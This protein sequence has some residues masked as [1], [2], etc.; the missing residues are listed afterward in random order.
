MVKVANLVADTIWTPGAG[1]NDTSP[2]LSIFL[3]TFRR[4]ADGLLQKVMQ[5]IADQTFRD[6]E[7]I[8]I[9]DAS[10]DGSAGI[11][12]DWMARDR[13]ISCLTHP[14][15]VGL[16]A[17][18]EFEA[19]LKS[20]GRFIGFAFDDFVYEPG[21]FEALV[22][23]ARAHPDALVHGYAEMVGWSGPNQFL[24]RAGIPAARLWHDNFI[25]NAT[26]LMPRQI[27]EA[28]GFY[29]PHI[30]AA[31]N[32][33]WDLWRRAQRHYPIVPIPVFIG[34]EHGTGRA[35]SLGRTYPVFQEVM[36]EFYGGRSNDVLLP[37]NL[38][39]RDVW[40]VP[41]P[42]SFALA[43]AAISTRKFF[44]NKAWA[45]SETMA[46]TADLQRLVEPK[47]PIIGV[48]GSLEATIS[49]CFDGVR[50]R[51]ASNLRFV[52][53]RS[54][55]A[56]QAQHI[57][58]CDAVIV[59]RGLLDSNAER[60]IGL[61]TSTGIDLH[62]LADD[63]PILIAKEDAELSRYRLDKVR[64]VLKP[65]KG[66]LATSPRLAEYYRANGLHPNVQL[67]G[68]VLDRATLGKMRRIVAEAHPGRL[69]VGFIGGGFREDDLRARVYPALRTLSQRTG[70]ELIARESDGLRRNPP[71]SPLP[72]RQIP[73]AL[74][75]DSFLQ[76]WRSL[77]IDVLVHPK[78]Q[79]LNIDY[80]TDSILVTSLYLGAVPIVCDEAAFRD[81]GESEGVLKVGEGP[82]DFA[83][84]LE[85]AS[86]PG[87]RQEMLRRLE[88]F[89]GRHFDPAANEKVLQ[90]ISDT[91]RPTDLIGYY[92]RLSRECARLSHYASEASN[93]YNSRAFKL[94]LKIR[95]A[96]TLVRRA[97]GLFR[98]RP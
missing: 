20:R 83:A 7:L 34:R 74:S 48:A 55:A 85:R 80:K 12:R 78:G 87:F 16:P 47:R 93:Q 14:R 98:R 79:T 94:A 57:L 65:F 70:I 50:D 54:L 91:T 43:A 52:D 62:Y 35:D 44:R 64:D 92:E 77:G 90:A 53:F 19:Y 36:F 17:V 89:C 63:N 69:R 66:V 61:C 31:R 2:E 22:E 27:V 28:I 76:T 29:D 18:S 38:P 21:A 75:Y 25:A 84:A 23:A 37:A 81:I 56:V 46:D 11:V 33:D 6:F 45:A 86:D 97:G 42:S 51:F 73:F 58:L 8:V 67:F 4:A 13:R 72:W 88:I 49:L 68:P 9:D 10:T 40:A 96:A 60:A 26:V 1:Y 95:Q 32:C 59:S 5:S 82:G 30:M 41:A 24:G 3:P 15:N 39:G 71:P